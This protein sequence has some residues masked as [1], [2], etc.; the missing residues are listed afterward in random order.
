MISRVKITKRVS[1]DEIDVCDM[2]ARHLGQLKASPGDGE[3]IAL[4]LVPDASVMATVVFGMSV[5]EFRH[6]RVVP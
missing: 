3:G 2:G 4:R 5:V 6:V 1:A